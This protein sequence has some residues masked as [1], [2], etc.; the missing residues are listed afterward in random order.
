[1]AN[2]VGTNTF[3]VRVTDNGAPA[4]N[5]TK[6]FDIVVT[7][8]LTITSF[9]ISNEVMSLDWRAIPGRS[10]TVEYKNSLSEAQW[11]PVATNIVTT[12]SSAFLS[13]PIG[14]NT[15]R[16]YRIVLQPE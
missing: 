6:T 4:L 8:S 13:D 2:N 12:N 7:A 11:K 3:L 14:T 10:Y 15:Q 16:I 5:D 1:M 9:A